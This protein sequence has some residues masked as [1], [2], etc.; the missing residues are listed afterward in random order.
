MMRICVKR[1]SFWRTFSGDGVTTGNVFDPAVAG[2]GSHVV[3]Y[4]YAD[5]CTAT[6]SIQLNVEIC[7]GVSPVSSFNFEVNPNPFTDVL[8]VHVP[9]SLPAEKAV[10]RLTDALGNVMKQ[11]PVSTTVFQ[12][13]REGLPAGLYMLIIESATTTA[14]KKV[15]VE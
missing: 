3:Y 1:F 4:T 15:V 7:T 10:F 2:I 5:F 12:V 6:D 14:R 11:G 9:A 13:K 8:T